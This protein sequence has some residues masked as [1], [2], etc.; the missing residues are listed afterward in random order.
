MAATLS[1]LG[2]AVIALGLALTIWA[3]TGRQDDGD[4][5]PPLGIG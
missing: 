1:W 4:D 2:L 3:W 5:E